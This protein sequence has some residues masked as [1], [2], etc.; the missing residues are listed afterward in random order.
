[1][2]LLPPPTSREL[3]SETMGLSRRQF[4]QRSLLLAAAAMASVAVA[5]CS[6]KRNQ[7]RRLFSDGEFATLEALADTVAPRGILSQGALD[8][9]VAQRFEQL[10]ATDHPVVQEQVRGGLIALEW[11]SLGFAAGRFSRL[12][13]KKRDDV[14]QQL[15]RSR[16]ALLRQIVQGLTGGLLFVYYNSP[17]L[18]PEI[19]YD[20]PWLRGQP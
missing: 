17:S 5:S 15:A 10:I 20:G 4:L 2:N 11:V 7:G 3:L 8:L 1:M 14:L 13:R 6:S 18:W 12:A 19:G 9:D 16:V